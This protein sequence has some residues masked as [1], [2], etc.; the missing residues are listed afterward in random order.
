[1]NISRSAGWVKSTIIS[2]TPLSLI[3]SITTAEV[4]LVVQQPGQS[5]HFLNGPFSNLV[6]DGE[7][8]REGSHLYTYGVA[9]LLCIIM[10]VTLLMF[11]MV[12]LCKKVLRSISPSRFSLRDES[13]MTINGAVRA[14]LSITYISLSFS[15]FS[16]EREQRGKPCTT[17]FILNITDFHPW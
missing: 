15:A 8:G 11:L 9:I 5:N 3:R 14:V 10:L 1:M 16:M 13:R 4:R 12:L 2:M 17:D 6:L 7:A